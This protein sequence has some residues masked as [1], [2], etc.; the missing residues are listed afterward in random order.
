MASILAHIQIHPGKEAVFE[1]ITRR[2]H[3]ATHAL[4]PD[5]L[6]YEYWRAAQAGKYYCFLCFTDYPAFMAH[7][8]SDHHEDDAE[9]LREVIADI[10]LEW[11]D[12]VM[13][14]AGFPETTDTA[15]APDTDAL[16]KEYAAMFPIE[17]QQ[18][19]HALRAP[20]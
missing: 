2:L 6:R 4:E 9:T 10:H 14:G 3:A 18:W 8:V 15:I 20:G 17:I 19:W 12:P 1:E 16:T 13:Q 11:L 5:C 7:Q